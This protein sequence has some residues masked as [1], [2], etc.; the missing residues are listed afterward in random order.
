MHDREQGCGV[1]MEAAEH[2]EHACWEVPKSPCVTGDGH[3]GM[4][5]RGSHLW[6]I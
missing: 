5:S 3:V 1:R 6:T 2:A 4:E